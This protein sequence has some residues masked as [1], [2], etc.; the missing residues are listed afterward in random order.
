[1]NRSLDIIKDTYKPYNYT[2]KGKS[3]I[4]K[5]T[6]GDI[7]VKEKQ[8]DIRALYE[9]L[10]TRNFTS[11]PPLIDD[12]RK[13]Y[14]IYSYV[15]DTYIPK[16]Q[17]ASDLIKLVANLHQKTTYYKEVTHDEYQKI[18]EKVKEQI[19]YLRFYYDQTFDEYFNEIYPSPSHYFLLTNCGKILA[20]F[21]FSLHELE[22]W[23]TKVSTLKKYRVCQIHNNLSL[24]HYRKSEQEYLL[25]WDKSRI[26][27]PIIDLIHFY[28]QEYFD[29]P[30]NSILENYLKIN[31]L[32]KEEQQLFFIVISM[33]FKVDFK[34]D[35]FKVC[36][37][38]RKVLD[39]VYKTEELIRP[40]YSKQEEQQQ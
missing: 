2:I 33:P 31:P 16:E 36:Q 23:Y 40:Y 35:E 22:N 25:S 3:H 26:D 10:R 1:M 20:A 29:L 37:E 19:E 9:Y 32:S 14:N 24:Q 15:S 7:V 21:D 39:Y 38:I 6:S 27:T 30:F 4:L 8:N 13:D 5:S 11:Y 18:Y 28:Q 12:S 34:G 17:K